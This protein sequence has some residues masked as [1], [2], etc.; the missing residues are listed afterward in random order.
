MKYCGYCGRVMADNDQFCANCGATAIPTPDAVP[1]D[2]QIAE[3]RAFLNYLYKFFKFERLMWKI[4]GI[5]F[6][7][8][9]GI[10][11]VFGLIFLFAGF[12]T[13]E[14]AFAFG[15]V[16][17]VLA[18]SITYLPVAIINFIMVSKT[19]RYMN[20]L[21]SEDVRPAITRAGSVGMIVFGALFNTVAM[22]FIIINFA[23]VKGNP[24]IVSRIFAR[25]DPN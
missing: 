4:F 10:F 1:E 22:I 2:M 13:G 24:Q 3:E 12:G 14:A 11:F 18:A 23:K 17:Y 21:L 7:V 8:C 20:T 16:M 6:L 25:Y 5:V 19:E 15:S 9:F